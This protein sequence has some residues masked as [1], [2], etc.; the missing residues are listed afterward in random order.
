[1]PN[2]CSSIIHRFSNYRFVFLSLICI[3]ALSITSPVLGQTISCQGLV[4]NTNIQLSMRNGCAMIIT[5]D[6]LL[7][8]PDENIDYTIELYDGNRPLGNLITENEL[9]KNIQYIIKCGRNSCSGNLIVENNQIPNF[10]APCQLLPNGQVNPGC[11]FWCGQDY[12]DAFITLDELDI[13]IDSMCFVK[14]AGLVR[15]ETDILGNICDDLG[16]LVTITYTA[17]FERHGRFEEHTFLTQAFYRQKINLD[18]DSTEFASKFG[19]PADIN[20]DCNDPSSPEDILDS[21][22]VYTNAYPYYYD[23]HQLVPDT[24]KVCDT[25]EIE[26]ILGPRK[27]LKKEILGDSAFWV[28]VTVI[29]K[30]IRDSVVCIRTPRV[31]QNGAIILSP[32]QVPITEKVCNIISSYEDLV[33]EACGKGEKILRNWSFIDWCDNNILRS[34]NQVIEISDTEA[35]VFLQPID[36]QIVSIDP[37]ICSAK[38]RLP[39]I[40]YYDN[41]SEDI[42]VEWVTLEGQIDEGFLFNLWIDASPLTVSAIIRDECGLSDTSTFE[43]AIIDEVPPVAICDTDI[44]I[45]LTGSDDSFDGGIAKLYAQELDEGSHDSNCGTVE[46][47]VVRKDD[48]SIPIIGCDGESLGYEPMSCFAKTEVVDQGFVDFT[49]TCVYSGLY[50]VPSVRKPSEFVKFCCEDAGKTIPV[51]MFAFDQ[52][53]NYNICEINV[54]V[55]NKNGPT[56]VCQDATIFCTDDIEKVARPTIIK[57]EFCDVSDNPILLLNE[58]IDDSNCDSILVTK[59]WYLD[60]DWNGIYNE[61]D[62]FCEQYITLL[63]SEVELNFICEPVEISCLDEIDS[64]PFPAITG[65]GL[66]DCNADKV[67]LFERGI[68]PENNLCLGQTIVRR[69]YVDL[70]ENNNID[71]NEPTCDQEITIPSLSEDISLECN[72]VTI[73]CLDDLNGAPEPTILGLSSCECDDVSLTLF[74]TN[75][76]EISCGIDV[77]TRIWFIDFNGDQNI[78]SDEP[79]CAQR[80]QVDYGIEN[81]E[82]ECNDVTISCDDDPSLVLSPT[83]VSNTFCDC[84]AVVIMSNETMT[85]N[86]CEN[87]TIHRT[88]FGDINENGLYDR[89]EPRCIQAIVVENNFENITLRC[90]D[91]TITCSDDLDDLPT[92]SFNANTCNCSTLEVK[93]A[94]QSSTNGL[95]LN[96][97][98]IREWYLDINNDNSFNAGEPSCEQSIL[99]ELGDVAIPATSR[100]LSS[101]TLQCQPTTISCEA[102]LSTLAPPNLLTNGICDCADLPIL[103]TS[104]SLNQDYCTGDVIFIDW[105]LDANGD[106]SFQEYEPSCRQEVTIEFTAQVDINCE[107]IQIMCTVDPATIRPPSAST[108]GFC[109]CSSASVILFEETISNSSCIMDTIRRTY[110]I[111]A[112]GDNEL[113]K[114]DPRCIQNIFIDNQSAPI[115]LSCDTIS[116]SCSDDLNALPEPTIMNNF[117]GCDFM[118]LTLLNQSSTEDLCI[119]DSIQREW[120]IDLNQDGQ[121]NSDEPFCDQTILIERDG[122]VSNDLSS[123]SLVCDTLSIPCNVAIQ[124]LF[125]PDIESDGFCSCDDLDVLQN[126][127]SIPTGYCLGDSVTVEWFLDANGDGSFDTGEPTCMHLIIIDVGQEIELICSDTTVVCNDDFTMLSKPAIGDIGFCSCDDDSILLAEETFS[128]PNCNVDTLRR[129]WYFDIDGDAMFD[130]REANCTQEILIDFLSVPIELSC[131]TFFISCADSLLSIPPPI[132]L[133]NSCNCDERDLILMNPELEEEV[134]I[135]DTIRQN[136]FLD[137]DGSG[138]L[139]GIEPFCTQVI[140]INLEAFAIPAGSSTISNALSLDC[141]TLTISCT[142]DLDNLAPP[143]LTS[144]G[145]CTCDQ[146]PVL[147]AQRTVPDNVCNGDTVLQ[148]WFADLDGNGLFTFNEPSCVQ[149]LV[150]NAD[151]LPIISCSDTIISCANSFADLETP[152]LGNQGFCDCMSN[153]VLLDSEV[154]PEF[155]CA[156][157]SIIRNWFIDLN[158]NAMSEADEPQCEQIIRIAN[159]FTAI[160]LNCQLQGLSCSDSLSTLS[161]PGN[162]FGDICSCGNDFPTILLDQQIEDDA[163]LG[164]TITRNWFIDINQDS[165]LTANEPS[166]EQVIIFS[167][168]TSFGIDCQDVSIACDGNLDDLPTPLSIGEGLCTC[169]DLPVRLIRQSD[170]EMRC[171]GD[172]LVREWY[173]DVNQDFVMNPDEPTCM[174]NVIVMAGTATEVMFN[175]S[176]VIVDCM[177]DLDTLTPP[178]VT[179]DGSCV[180]SELPVLA[181]NAAPEFLCAGD[182]ILFQWYVDMDN[183]NM[184]NEGDPSCDQ[185]I[186]IEGEQSR[187]DPFTIKWPKSFDDAS[188]VGI[189]LVCRGDTVFAE[190]KVIPL[191]NSFSCMPEDIDFQP[192][193]CDSDC[194]LISLSVSRD[195]IESAEACFQLV[196]R[197]TI[198]DWCTFDPEETDS[199]EVDDDTFDIILDNAQ[200]VCIDCPDFGPTIQD[201]VYARFNV[202]DVDGFYVYEQ[203]L[204]VEDNDPPMI[205]IMQD[206]VFVDVAPDSLNVCSGIS[207]VMASATDF[208]DNT[209][210]TPDMIQWSVRVLDIDR[211]I[212]PDENG[213]NF[214]VATGSAITVNTRIGMANDT[215]TIVWTVRDACNTATVRETKV[216]FRDTLDAC[217]NNFTEGM[218]SGAVFT[219]DNYAVEGT[220]IELMTNLP[221]Y[222][223]SDM[224]PIEGVFA[225]NDNPMSKNYKLTAYKDDFDLNGVSA[226][227]MVFIQRHILGVESL[228]SGYK[229]IAADVNND[230]KISVSDLT[231]LKKLILGFSTTFDENTSWKFVPE[232]FEILDHADPWPIKTYYD[233]LDFKG[234]M[235][236]ENF[237]GIKIG[238]VTGDVVPNQEMKVV[239]REVTSKNL[240]ISDQYVEE[241]ELIEIDVFMQES[242][243]IS[244]LLFALDFDGLELIDMSKTEVQFEAQES[245]RNLY[246]MTYLSYGPEATYVAAKNPVIRLKIKGLRSGKISDMISIK[247]DK[248]MPYV[249]LGHEVVEHPLSLIFDQNARGQKG[250]I[251]YQ[252]MPNPFKEETTIK[253]TVHVSQNITINLY[254]INGRLLKSEDRFYQKGQHEITYFDQDFGLGN[255]LFLCKF[256]TAQQSFM[257]RLIRFE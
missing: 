190:D 179:S 147:Q 206:T 171:A 44:Q 246:D 138:T 68:Q 211:N 46:L 249:Y 39:Q 110:Y 210:S 174:Q 107:D 81:F 55:V 241:G 189:E 99:I 20:L 233:I 52:S 112:D 42:E 98:I 37:W 1:M 76:T 67:K 222:P 22:G 146:L 152:R 139:N 6:M 14:P 188:I 66:C 195:T 48:W 250:I 227:D 58:Q 49:G 154:I 5:P 124:D 198:I 113:S 234:N 157:D 238:D 88:Y 23:L 207:D 208:C 56:I 7:E 212:I 47:L 162:N 245:F 136:W 132:I 133:N 115:T 43:I 105:Y 87:D 176:P 31:D 19:Y 32:A 243:A 91:L 205:T 97:E 117:C 177:A 251:V 145:F 119:D 12:P 41:C 104:A 102:E 204:N 100:D 159:D 30:E 111:D 221:D 161:V 219:E 78:N 137:L 130:P 242:E 156:G 61:S 84:D 38:I 235:E 215:F 126:P 192:V 167:N 15:V 63:S 178:T 202:V 165:I 182:T 236:N 175:C 123:I 26:V 2:I 92:P 199:T 160:S 3:V 232:H 9:D 79:F 4:C 70:N 35:P 17:K 34:E 187:L 94:D 40:E 237:I 36:D 214:N 163:C 122:E 69:F 114:T 29:D 82:F 83:L 85:N 181:V 170:S 93:L 183:N 166:C 169:S 96:D 45:Q 33:F 77:L 127:N 180:C 226:R 60:S 194:G 25:M 11:V 186:I 200:G 197:F 158:G 151:I 120:Y 172:T 54:K 196:N 57:G 240:V 257:K 80:I 109:D 239:P 135:G 51:L 218:I 13:I 148:E 90:S 24:I 244:A 191:G 220:N 164:D 217:P 125:P 131:D 193:W 129:T 16:E 116:V 128:E 18:L 86:T 75:S 106:M 150:I 121:Y 213:D 95:C 248:F 223:I 254:D 203:R 144:L 153:P 209:M 74:S 71:N 50:R 149:S 142:E 73:S 141:D 256:S 27:V 184:F 173:L 28:V 247:K 62:P 255:N 134:C 59:Q 64:V 230:Q 103:A 185:E 225:F 253:F 252:N 216:I 228:S 10:N 101:L 53:G 21:T 65:G 143:T 140:E 231:I 168:A 72:D 224:T 229:A 8:S 155:I 201:S 108:F 89:F 118:E